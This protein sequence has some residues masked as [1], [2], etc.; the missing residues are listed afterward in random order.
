MIALLDTSTAS[1]QLTLVDGDKR[2]DYEWQ[3]DRQLAKGLL[4]FVEQSLTKHDA[5]FSDLTGLAVLRGPGSYT[6]LR[7]GI[8]VFNTIADTRQIPI[9]GAV[10]DDWQAEALQSL[11][12]GKN[13]QLV[14]PEYGGEANITQPRK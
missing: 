1:C 4:S 12:A 11:A 7:I 14:I 13:D 9:V 6:G 8:T 10:G 5:S 3:A 2:H